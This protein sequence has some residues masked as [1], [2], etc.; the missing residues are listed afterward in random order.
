MC[1]LMDMTNVPR[2]GFTAREDI[3]CYKVL[4]K[5]DFDTCWFGAYRRGAP[6]ISGESVRSGMGVTG[7]VLEVGVFSK[8]KSVWGKRYVP[9]PD[10]PLLKRRKDISVSQ[11]R[12][13]P[14]M[15][16]SGAGIY[17]YTY[18]MNE[19]MEATVDHMREWHKKD[20]LAVARCVIPA[21][22]R[23]YVSASGMVFVSDTLRVDEF[24][25]PFKQQMNY[26][27]L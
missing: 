22:S 19:A 27:L 3:T 12:P 25:Y 5:K 16:Y 20:L 17:S 21:G 10:M 8:R 26:T 11:A 1:S 2:G 6:Y 15:T 23:Y 24:I 7:G 13:R 9:E 4:R 14:E 18:Y